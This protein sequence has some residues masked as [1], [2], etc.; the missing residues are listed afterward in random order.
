MREGGD[1]DDKGMVIVTEGV[2]SLGGR[3]MAGPM[4]DGIVLKY[5]K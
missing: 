3:E 4:K 1:D 2:W 5:E